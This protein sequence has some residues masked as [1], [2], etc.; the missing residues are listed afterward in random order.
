MLPDHDY[1]IYQNAL[2]APWLSR[3]PDLILPS[4]LFTETPGTIV[5]LWGKVLK[6]EKAV[7]P[8]AG[9]RPDWSIFSE[10]AKS[11]GKTKLVYQGTESVQAAI[12]KQIK[13][14]PDLKKGL[15]FAGMSEAP[16]KKADTKKMPKAKGSTLTHPF[17]L[18]WKIDQDSYRGIPLAEAVTGM[19][20][21]GNRGYLIINA[22]DATRIGV[23]DNQTVTM[24]SN[25]SS[26]EFAVR[27]SVD[28]SVG[29]V[30]LVSQCSVPFTGNPCAVQIRR[31]N[32]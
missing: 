13:G 21:I 3:A 19:K 16:R 31:N 23:D 4:A 22:E 1:L 12:R 15:Q 32:E 26:L 6:I 30:H 11:M 18:Y 2:P 24:S 20:A 8:F 9:S 14:F 5:N 28:T 27:T 25:G 10:I 7:E 29:T 17:L